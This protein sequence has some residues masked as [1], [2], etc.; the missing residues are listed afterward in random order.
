MEKFK[1]ALSVL[2][3]LVSFN[4]GIVVGFIIMMYIVVITSSIHKLY[5]E[6]VTEKNIDIQIKEEQLKNLKL[7]NAIKELEGE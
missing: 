3:K 2:W 5:N 7:R 1:K 4:V 6:M